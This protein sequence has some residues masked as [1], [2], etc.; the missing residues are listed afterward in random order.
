MSGRY[1]LDVGDIVWINFTPQSGH[2]QA[3]RRP[4]VVLSPKNYNHSVTIRTPQVPSESFLHPAE[5]PIRPWPLFIECL[6]SFH[7]SLNAPLYS[8]IFFFFAAPGHSS[9]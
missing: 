5:G 9:W 3:G 7:S 4:A 1:I 8:R 2:E 6:L